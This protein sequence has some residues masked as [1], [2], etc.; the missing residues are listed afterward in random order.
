[1][2]NGNLR[3]ED[4]ATNEFSEAE[5]PIRSGALLAECLARMAGHFTSV[6]VDYVVPDNHSRLTKKISHKQPWNSWNYIVA[7]YAEAMTEN[8]GNIEWRIHPGE[9]AEVDV[10]GM[11]Y[12]LRDEIGR[13]GMGVVYEA[14][15]VSLGRP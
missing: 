10:C 5:Q 12:L 1:M 3:E 7:K 6:V 11:R 4:N 13:G 2:V 14:E 9:V 8:I 15:Q